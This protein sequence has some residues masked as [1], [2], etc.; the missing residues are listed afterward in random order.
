[1]KKLILLAALAAAIL[2]PVA[3]A[4]EPIKIGV[5]AALTGPVSGTYAPTVEGLRLYIDRMNATGGID[6]RKIQLLI[7]DDRGEPSRA[8][9]NARRI[10]SEDVVLI[11]NSSLSSTY[12]PVVASAKRADVPLLFAAGVC[13]PEVYPPADPNLF[14]TTAYAAHYDSRA[15]L[16]F[17]AEQSGTDVRLGLHA[18]AI[19]VSRAEIDYA[20]KLAE[21][22]GMTPVAKVITPPATPSYSSFATIID[23]A[24]ATWVWSWAPWGAQAETFQALRRLGWD[25]QYLTWAHLPAEN[26]LARIQDPYLYAIGANA[27]FFENLPIM[28]TIVDAAKAAD[29][30]YPANQMTGGWIAGMVIEAALK[31]ASD[32]T[33]PESVREAMS[34]LRVD[35]EGLRGGPLVW[36]EDNHFRTKQYYRVYRWNAEDNRIEIVSDWTAFEV[37]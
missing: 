28:Q 18:M 11:V 3:F 35:T 16:N 23:K 19:P 37:E 8:A 22:M 6:G 12:P 21:K 9:T 14:C 20:E 1:M 10:L 17:I 2:V 30:E 27:M 34:H 7:R 15:A 25:G 32:P 13:P 24:D 36:T 5:T 26:A 31:G 4:K 29:S 33:S